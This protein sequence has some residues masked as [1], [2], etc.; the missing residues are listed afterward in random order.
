MGQQQLLLL[1]LSIVIVGMAVA[2]GIQS[3]SENQRKSNAD[4]L[5]NDAIR[6][7]ADAQ[8]WTL[9]PT[10]L[11]G[12]NGAF[13]GLG[14]EKLGYKAGDQPG[15]DT[16]AADDYETRAAV[17]T[18]TVDDAGQVT[19]VGCNSAFGNTV[20]AIIPRPGMGETTTTVANGDC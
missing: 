16:A 15:G 7:A 6:I 12:G 5:V 14:F 3:F 2:V 4:I 20:T 10:V 19:L 8:A 11:G 17:F 13:T 1:V 9:K 18:L